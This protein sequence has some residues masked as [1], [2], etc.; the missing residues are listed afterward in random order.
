MGTFVITGSFLVVLVVTPTF[1]TNRVMGHD[2]RPG[3][4]FFLYG[5]PVGLGLLKLK[6]WAALSLGIPSVIVAFW[7]IIGSLNR[8]PFPW[9]LYNFFFGLIMLI[10]LLFAAVYWRDL[11]W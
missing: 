9:I 3:I 5:F 8:V 7:L 4:I 11:K 6:R 2:I 10:P 1:F